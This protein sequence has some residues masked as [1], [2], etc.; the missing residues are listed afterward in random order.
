MSVLPSCMY[1]DWEGALDPLD[2]ELWMA[3]TPSGYLWKSEEGIRSLGL[4]QPRAI[5]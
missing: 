5:M 2:L 1:G 3:E 4:E